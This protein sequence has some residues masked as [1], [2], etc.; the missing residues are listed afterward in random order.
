MGEMW[1]LLNLEAM[2]YFLKST[3]QLKKILMIS[4][5]MIVVE[6]VFIIVEL[7]LLKQAA[8]HSWLIRLRSPPLRLYEWDLVT[9]Y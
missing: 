1:F 4:S 6:P 7:L 8:T 5:L 3:V 2:E 9:Q